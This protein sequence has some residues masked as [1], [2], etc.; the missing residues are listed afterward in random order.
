[1]LLW[2]YIA[3]RY[4]GDFVPFLVLAS[5]VAMADIFRRLEGRKRSLRIVT[6][7]VI[8]LVALFSIAANIGM[9]IVPNEEWSTTQVLHYVETQ[10]A[11][12]DITG[13]PLNADVVRGNSLPLW[14]PAGQL[15]IIGKCDG[16]YISN[17]ENYSTVPLQQFQRTTWMTVEL[18]PAF[19]HMFR[20]TAKSPE[21]GRTETVP[22]VSAGRYMVTVTAVPTTDPH[23]LRLTF[24]LL[25]VA[26]HVY[27]FSLRVNSGATRSVL[28]TTDP[29]KHHLEVA[30]GG[31]DYLSTTL[32]NL[33]PIH[34]DSANSHSQVTGQA[35]SVTNESV[36]APQ[37]TL[38]Q[39]LTP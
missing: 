9:A 38:C 21:A 31:L 29:A 13:H 1:L 27:K 37:P 39:S 3:P 14:G 26:G 28:V 15:F 25:G 35:L 4:L 2:G 17:G 34:V 32:P 30:I 36:T 22:L 23:R 5:A 33:R 16:L 12:S 7:S 6:V 19:E 18:S 8:A 20:V 10:K 11:I 24:G